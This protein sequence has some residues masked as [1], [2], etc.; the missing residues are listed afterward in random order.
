MNSDLIEK[1]AREICS[2]GGNDPDAPCFHEHWPHQEYPLWDLYIPEARAAI[3]LVVEECR[4]RA[5]RTIALRLNAHL[6]DMR[7]G[8]DD[9]ITGFNEAWTIAEAAASDALASLSH[10]R[11]Q[12][13]VRDV[14]GKRHS[15]RVRRRL[16]SWRDAA[17]EKD[18]GR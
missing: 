3:R 12:D 10:R 7:P 17:Q 14:R 9:S 4:Q 18:N 6:C 15:M 16:H 13:E 2:E 11:N 1:V 5:K 8:Y